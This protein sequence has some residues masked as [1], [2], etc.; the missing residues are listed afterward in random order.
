MKKA[1]C[2]I[3]LI[4]LLAVPYVGAQM[5]GGMM[6]SQG[7]KGHMERMMQGHEVA[8]DMI[9]HMG[10]MTRLM[11]QIREIMAER[12]D[13]ESMKNMSGLMEG[14][15]E[16]LRNM[17]RVM[18]KGTAS[19]KEIEELNRQNMIMQEKYEKMRW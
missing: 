13:T 5:G 16:H 7:T 15:S 1:Q 6:G 10:Q 14:M 12:P 18:K 19:Q 11:Q 17:S 9:H 2:M 8:G 4:S 3:L